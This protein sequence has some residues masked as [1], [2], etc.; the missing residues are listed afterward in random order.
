M[1]RPPA[2]VAYREAALAAKPVQPSPT[3]SRPP[4]AVSAPSRAEALG[5]FCQSTLDSLPAQV[6]LLDEHGAIVAVNAAWRAFGADNDGD[7]RAGL[8]ESYL[9]VYERA[10]GTETEE[11]PAVA[12]GLRAV[13][14]GRC[15]AFE[16]EYPCGSPGRLRR[17]VV[18]A[19]PFVGPGSA[20][21]IVQHQDVTTRY[22]A[23]AA[24]RLNARLLDAV[25]AAVVALDLR[26]TVILWNR[27]AELLYGWSGEE[28]VGRPASEFFYAG[29]AAGA[30]A[31]LRAEGRWEGELELARRDGSRFPAYVRYSVLEDVEGERTGYV[32][33]SID[34]AERHRS[35]LALRSARDYMAAVT[36]S[37]GDGL[38]TLD[39]SGRVVYLN[40][41]G[42]ELLGW[43]AGELAGR[44]LHEVVQYARADGSPFP[45]EESLLVQARR[46]GGPIRVDDD[47][48]IRRDGS[49]VEVQQ[50]MTPFV[51]EQ[52]V[53][54]FVLVFSDIATRKREQRESAR[55][56]ADLGWIERI[57]AALDEDRF[58]LHAQPIVDVSSGETVQHELLI[59]MVADDGSL[60][61]PGEFLPIAETYGLIGEIDRWVV[62][63][64][65][66][67]TAE[68]HAIELN[69]SAHSLGDPTLYAYVDAELRRTG[70]DPTLLIFELTETAILRDEE[71]AL[72][73]A[74]A[75][76]AR[77]CKLALDDFGTGYGGFGYLKRL[78]VSYLKIDIEF[79]RDL[80][81]EPASRQVV[82]AVINL[83][84][85]FGIETVAE[86]VEDAATLTLLGL[87]GVDFV[88]GFHL[89][90]PAALENMRNATKGAGQ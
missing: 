26:G 77:G 64:A 43:S 50:V 10:T 83:A 62:G 6:A 63:Q 7:V 32:G 25:D 90:R 47:T 11:V 33:V 68:G 81:S 55:K 16:G 48:I 86:G 24:A 23:Q 51:T 69:L 5:G 14:D 76:V 71:T 56:L 8:G 75:I 18:R 61:A 73:F 13:L 39:Q 3:R 74:T 36:D 59:R 60:I 27:G 2:T 12:A 20:R 57:R 49:L 34:I 67:L 4:R 58:V 80:A 29:S 53:G 35:E 28:A 22:E 40:P 1:V 88:Q 87:L 89:G 41:R 30:I 54:G 19:A 9:E 72:R 65:L 17:F 52:G 79:V 44:D 46:R 70:A 78:P 82:D 84:R 37:I 38:C 15:E 21:V 45:A 66:G 85:G 42:E 31:V